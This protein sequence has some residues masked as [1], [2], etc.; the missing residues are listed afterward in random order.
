MA[1]LTFLGFK[2]D[3]TFLRILKLHHIYIFGGVIYLI[4]ASLFHFIVEPIGATI[5]HFVIKA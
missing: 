2:F 4:F 1:A 5:V 3:L